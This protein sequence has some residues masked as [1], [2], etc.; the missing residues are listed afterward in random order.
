MHE[1]PLKSTIWIP[2]V[3]LEVPRGG[4][5]A[6]E[7]KSIRLA[8]SRAPLYPGERMAH[9]GAKRP[10]RGAVCTFAE[11]DSSGTA[12]WVKDREGPQVTILVIERGRKLYDWLLAG[13]IAQ[14]LAVVDPGGSGWMSCGIY[15]EPCG[16]NWGCWIADLEVARLD[17]TRNDSKLFILDSV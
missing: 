7:I 8:K 6:S 1:K 2:T 5:L 13:N 15:E 16:Q 11:V 3:A 12:R 17:E 9:F 14:A 10:R 4:E